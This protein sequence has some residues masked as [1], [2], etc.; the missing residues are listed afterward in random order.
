[1]EANIKLYNDDVQNIY[2]TV[3]KPT[4]II[5]DGPYGVKG[6]PG[7]T[8]NPRL[9]P[10][11]YEPHIKKWSE[12]ATPQTTL[13]FWN[14]EIGWAM[15]HP[16]L[17]KY[18]WE[19]K[20]TQVWDKGKGHIAGNVNT[21]SLSKFPIVT[22]L[23][24]QYTKKLTFKD[25]DDTISPKE[26]LRKEWL[27]TG[28]PL[29]KTNEACGVKNAATRKYFTQCNLWYMPPNDAFEKIVNYANE[30]GK[31]EGRP[32]FSIDGENSLSKQDWDD[33]QPKFYCPFGYTNVWN[34]PAL[35]TSERLKINGKAIHT[36]QKPLSLMELII[37]ISS[38]EGDLVF[39]PFGG[40]FTGAVASHKLGRNYISSE[41]TPEVYS[42]GSKRFDDYLQTTKFEQTTL[43]L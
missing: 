41:I 19:Y 26:W 11:W 3:H 15:V 42:H 20:A 28:M 43:S 27:R 30:F 8:D 22:E 21:K 5:S 36:N 25:G 34:V 4:V 2:N 16:I 29:N 31:P 39:E 13:W 37:E 35:H 10:E 18:G 24:V 1:M 38:D 6:F 32:Y 40:L 12:I 14:T 17:E 9:L 33:L 7:D 23:C